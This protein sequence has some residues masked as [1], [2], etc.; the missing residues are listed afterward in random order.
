MKQLGEP[1]P[2]AKHW[3]YREV[4]GPPNCPIMVRWTLF[5]HG[6][7]W[8]KLLVHHFL[9]NA[10]DRAVHDHPRGFVTVVLKGRYDDMKPCP[11]CEGAGR[12]LGVDQ[13]AEVG[14]W[15]APP[16]VSVRC[17]CTGGVVLNE[18]MH[19]R[20]VRYRPAE[21]QHRTKVGPRGCWTLV[22]M[23]P[24]R[25]SWGFIVGGAWMRWAEFE[26]RFGWGMRCG[27]EDA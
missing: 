21:H 13:D 2:R 1:A 8:P 18:R 25:R 20:V 19:A 17:D 5:A 23:G 7:R 24:L 16:H 26:R 27:D 9:P 4:I 15:D 12:Y 22:V 3:P 6:D 14:P 11:R 10:D